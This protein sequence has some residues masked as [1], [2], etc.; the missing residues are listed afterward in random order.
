[1]RYTVRY[2]GFV[3]YEGDDAEKAYEEY[4]E[5]GPYG[6]IFETEEVE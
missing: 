1:M 5:C 4:R 2:G 6:Q 3:I